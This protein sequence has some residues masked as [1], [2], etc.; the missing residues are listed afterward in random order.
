MSNRRKST[1]G[2]T[3]AYTLTKERTALALLAYLWQQQKV[4]DD[5]LR[6]L[7]NGEEVEVRLTNAQA[8]EYPVVAYQSKT[9]K[10]RIVSEDTLQ[11][12]LDTNLVD[13]DNFTRVAVWNDEDG[14]PLAKDATEEFFDS[15]SHVERIFADPTPSAPQPDTPAPTPTKDLDTQVLEFLEGLTPDQRNAWLTKVTAVIQAMNDQ[16]STGNAMDDWLKAHAKK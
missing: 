16:P 15:I 12:M 10:G 5:Q 8:T 11:E 2:F 13:R 4:N 9:G 14:T 7:A 1:G 3:T 6:Q